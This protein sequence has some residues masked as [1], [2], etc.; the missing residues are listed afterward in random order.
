MG[1]AHHSPSSGWGYQRTCSFVVFHVLVSFPGFSKLL[2]QVHSDGGS[3]TGPC[4]NLPLTTCP[5]KPPQALQWAELGSL[6][7]A[8]VALTVRRATGHRGKE[9]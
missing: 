1:G 3:G 9:S 2:L 5:S 8:M 6:T 7:G 4:D